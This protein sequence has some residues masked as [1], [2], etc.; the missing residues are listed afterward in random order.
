[1]KNITYYLLYA[2]VYTFTITPA[3]AINID[4]DWIQRVQPNGVSFIGR[5]YGDEFAMEYETKDGYKYV[6]DA[7]SG[8]YTYAVL[9]EKGDY[10]PSPWRVG[11]DNPTN[12]EIWRSLLRSPSKNSEIIYA[13]QKEDELR[14]RIFENNYSSNKYAGKKA[15]VNCTL[16]AVLIDFNSP[17]GPYG[18]YTSANF[19]SLLYG[20][21]TVTSPDS[22]QVFG[23]LKKYLNDLSDGNY[24]ITGSILNNGNWIR[25]SQQKSNYINLSVYAFEDTMRI[26]AKNAGVDTTTSATRKIVYIYA[27]NLYD[28]GALV[29]HARTN[30]YVVSEKMDSDPTTYRRNFETPYA[31]FAHVGIHAH[32]FAHMLGAGDKRF[33]EGYKA[34]YYCL[35]GLGSQNGP[36]LFSC[37]SLIDPYSKQAIFGLNV[38]QINSLVLDKQLYYKSSGLQKIYKVASQ[39]NSI[40]YYIEHRTN[41]SF[42]R[43]IKYYATSDSMPGL[44]IWYR[45][46]TDDGKIDLIQADADDSTTDNSVKSDPFPGLGNVTNIS[47][48]TEPSNLKIDNYYPRIRISNISNHDSYSTADIY[49]N[50]WENPVLGYVHWYDNDVIVGD[51]ITISSGNL[52]YVH[53][54][55][56]VSL[57]GHYIKK[58][59]G[60]FHDLGAT[61]DKYFKLSNSGSLK[62]MFSTFKSAIDN[63]SSGD[64]LYI[65]EDVTIPSGETVTVISGL[66]V[67]LNGHSIKSTGGT[68]QDAG[69]TWDK[70]FKL[71]S[72]GSLKG[73]FSNFK[74]A[75][76]N[77]SSGE[78]LS[79][80]VDIEE[81]VNEGETVSIPSNMIIKTKMINFPNTGRLRVWGTLNIAGGVV[82][83]KLDSE[84]WSG[85]TVKPEGALNVTGGITVK[86]SSRFLYTDSSDINFPNATSTFDSCASGA[87]DY[88]FKI[89]NCSPLIR[90]IRIKN[91]AASPDGY[92]AIWAN[93]TLSCPNIEWCTIKDAYWGVRITPWADAILHYC[94]LDSLLDDCIHMQYSQAGSVDMSWG[95][96][97]VIPAPGKYA[98]YNTAQN[99]TSIV[100]ETYFGPNPIASNLFSDSTKVRWSFAGSPFDYGAPKAAP[101]ERNPFHIARE[102]EE[103]KDWDRALAVYEDVVRN[104]VSTSQ[105]RMAIKQIFKVDDLS[106]RSFSNV[107]QIIGNEMPS[108]S[109]TFRPFLDF[110]LC[111]ILIK[112]RNYR[113]AV[114]E[115]LRNAEVYKGS[116]MEL[117]M[118]VRAA[119]IYG[120]Y[121]DDKVKAKEYADRVAAIDPGYEML[122]DAY[123]SA[124]IEY[125]PALYEKKTFDSSGDAI[126]TNQNQQ[127]PSTDNTQKEYVTVSPNPSNAVIT[128]SF[129]IKSPSFVKLTIYSINGQ[130]VATLADGPMS[131]GVHSVVFN[132]SRYASGVYFYRF[133]SAGMK[134][135]G[136]M[137]LLK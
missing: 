49:T 32:E 29:C 107:R 36:R 135:T 35:M 103:I 98:I 110:M 63:A 28:Y 96:N 80:K 17:N 112:E 116:L 11:I 119:N 50:Y 31:T 89:C 45:Y 106:K 7:K 8:Y 9:N 16:D 10:S 81:I 61:W 113:Q 71:S 114:S 40:E 93:G 12:H 111:E 5:E 82:F 23:S 58:T 134:R 90:N 26:Y 27:G 53:Q 75:I 124:G 133:E 21:Y 97:D 122:E 123:M 130:K 30:I 115:F 120:D 131:A 104:S 56:S 34:R 42:T 2:M 118:L 25:L 70:Y 37:P 59:G 95:M 1:M 99:D 87:A 48:Y 39:S 127:Q 109:A 94:V 88:C 91:S 121:L 51:N 18:T 125:N 83:D 20:N 132:G 66:N 85:I 46:N 19:D 22:Q 47:D 68:F 38:E 86:H 62:G 24:T 55:A 6:Y 128:I 14:K 44:L 54:G 41:D 79:L 126:N 102:Y 78:T 136:K 64:T 117:E 84:D 100:Y 129:S 101:F 137:L 74:S 52:L 33:S 15:V 67:Y 105:K 69:A 43:Y 77:A 60:F 92:G 4:T 65:G 13:R 108:A 3:N 72:G 57:N 73:M 76:E